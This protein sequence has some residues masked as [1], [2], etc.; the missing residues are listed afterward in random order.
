MRTTVL[1][2]VIA[3]AGLVMVLGGWWALFALYLEKTVRAAWQYYAVAIG[4]IAGGLSMVGLAQALRLL[5]AIY[6]RS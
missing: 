3:G 2:Y 4:M 1:A 5:A 6:A